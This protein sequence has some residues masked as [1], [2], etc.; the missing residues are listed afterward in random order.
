MPQYYACSTPP[1]WNSL[2]RRMGLALTCSRSRPISSFRS[3]AKARG[4]REVCGVC[5]CVCGRG[6]GCGVG[7]VGCGVWGGV[8]C[9]G[10]RGGE[11]AAD[12]G[13]PCGAAAEPGGPC[14]SRA[15]LPACSR[16]PLWQHCTHPTPPGTSRPARRGSCQSPRP[17]QTS[18]KTGRR[19]RATPGTRRC[20]KAGG[21]G[22][23]GRS[24]GWARG[25]AGVPHTRCCPRGALGME[26][27][28]GGESRSG[29]GV[30]N[31]GACA[32]TL[33]TARPAQCNAHHNHS[34]R[35][36]WDVRPAHRM[37]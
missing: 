10:G 21:G 4:V 8:G 9:G 7:G 31:N 22:R 19:R 15:S 20:S 30:M 27:R 12:K 17:F 32:V 26:A 36:P 24:G 37:R 2:C 3:S 5:G 13:H 34:E 1:T 25:T 18:G 29:S 11:E 14:T 35:P 16:I 23:A 6:V 28:A 33:P